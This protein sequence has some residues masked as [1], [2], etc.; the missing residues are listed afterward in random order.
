M[1]QSFVPHIEELVEESEV[2]KSE[3]RAALKRAEQV[4][5]EGNDLFKE[6]KYEESLVSIFRSVS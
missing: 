6:G 4:K 5:K 3:E 2:D 1:E